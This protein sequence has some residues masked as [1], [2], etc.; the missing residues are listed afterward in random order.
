MNSG[1]GS[2]VL[3]RSLLTTNGDGVTHSVPLP[4]QDLMETNLDISAHDGKEIYTVMNRAASGVSDTLILIGHG[5]T[6]HP[7]EY[8]HQHARNFFTA[9]GYDIVRMAFYW[10]GP[11]RRTL[12]DCT[13]AL[14]A[15]DVL[16]VI[17]HYK[18]DYK[19]IFYIG[20]SYG[21]LTGLVANPDVDGVVFWDSTYCPNWM[22]GEVVHIPE[23]D[24]YRLGWGGSNLIGKAMYDEAMRLTQTHVDEMAQAFKAP[25]LVVKSGANPLNAGPEAL[26]EGLSD[27]KEYV[28]I[29][30]AD[31]CFYTGDTVTDLLEQTEKWIS[32]VASK[33]GQA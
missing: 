2:E 16:S 5:L 27:P 19:K 26:Y 12:L 17:H 20:H 32:S 8:L 9:K 31:H 4:L 14:H 6:G 3:L 1:Q 29:K 28:V 18:C 30:D 33:N 21:G 23:A 10:S 24:V 7:Y 25:A 11:N 15:S 22:K 13:L